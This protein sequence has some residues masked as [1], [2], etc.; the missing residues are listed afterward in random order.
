MAQEKIIKDIKGTILTVPIKVLKED[1][2]KAKELYSRLAKRKGWKT[3]A[4]EQLR[5]WNYIYK[6]VK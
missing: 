5:Y 1:S 3:E 6:Q 2:I 4:K